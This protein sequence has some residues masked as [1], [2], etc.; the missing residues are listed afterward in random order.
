[1]QLVCFVVTKMAYL[2]LPICE[3]FNVIVN[4]FGYINTMVLHFPQYLRGKI[5]FWFTFDPGK[6]SS[7]F[8]IGITNV[9][10]SE[11]FGWCDGDS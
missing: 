10:S 5:N 8:D 1:M 7:I 3:Y 9:L 4:R 11:Q 2:R 6:A